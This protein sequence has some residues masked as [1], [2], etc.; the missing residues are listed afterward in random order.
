MDSVKT[1][2]SRTLAPN[3]LRKMHHFALNV[4]DLQVSRHFYGNILALHELTGEE[5]PKLYEN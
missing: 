5:I 1:S 4:Q 3:S 2:S